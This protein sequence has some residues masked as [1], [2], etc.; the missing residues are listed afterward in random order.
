MNRIVRRGNG[1]GRGAGRGNQGRCGGVRK[2]DGSGRGVGNINKA[3][4][5]KKK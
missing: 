1:A 4:K 3:K 5:T 2:F